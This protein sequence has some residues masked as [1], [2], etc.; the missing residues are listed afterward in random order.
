MQTNSAVAARMPAFDAAGA[1]RFCWRTR[2]IR[3]LYGASRS[4][5]PS[6]EPSSTTT[7]SWA[8]TVWASADST[9]STIDSAD[10]YVAM[11]IE[12]DGGSPGRR[13]GGAGGARIRLTAAD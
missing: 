1:P 2:T 4:A 7:T 6:V 8:G 5:V 3:S 10:W 9:E 11:T 13:P 12:N